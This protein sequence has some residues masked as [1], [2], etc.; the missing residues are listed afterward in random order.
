MIESKCGILCA[1]CDFRNKCGCG[2]CIETDGHPFYGACSVANCCKNK[3]VEFCGEC[4]EFPC[5]LLMRFSCDPEHGDNPKG[6]RIEQCMEWIRFP[7]SLEERLDNANACSTP[8]NGKS[9]MPD[10]KEPYGKEK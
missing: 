3:D 6:A 2:G 9:P 1:S 4:S 5:D 7:I 10:T 8:T